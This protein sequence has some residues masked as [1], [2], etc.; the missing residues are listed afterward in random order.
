MLLGCGHGR[1]HAPH[2]LRRHGAPRA[3]RQADHQATWRHLQHHA[4]QPRAHVQVLLGRNRRSVNCVSMHLRVPGSSKAD[5]SCCCCYCSMYA[6]R[7][8]CSTMP[9]ALTAATSN[10]LHLVPLPPPPPPRNPRPAQAPSRPLWAHGQPAQ[11]RCCTKVPEVS[12]HTARGI[13]RPATQTPVPTHKG[14]G[15]SMP[16]EGLCHATSPRRAA[17]HRTP[18]RTFARSTSTCLASLPSS[19]A[20]P[21]GPGPS[22]ASPSSSPP[23]PP[24]SWRGRCRMDRMV[25]K[26]WEVQAF[27]TGWASLWRHVAHNLVLLTRGTYRPPGCERRPGDAG[28]LYIPY[29][30]VLASWLLVS[31]PRRAPARP[32]AALPP[33]PLA[34]PKL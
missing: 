23:L 21:P 25:G 1:R 12:K 33:W 3:V 31:F 17:P 29:C 15:A 19:P 27:A 32:P 14:W 10:R 13:P 26:P 16:G 18:R 2:L 22:S 30:S 34:A 8:W 20:A 5:G 7:S 9:A 28:L 4:P 6:R 24:R 11:A